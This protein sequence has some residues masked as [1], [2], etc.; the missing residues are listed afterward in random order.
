VD[1]FEKIPKIQNFRAERKVCAMQTG[2]GR[3]SDFRVV[4]AKRRRQN[5]IGTASQNFLLKT[6]SKSYFLGQG[7]PDFNLK[8]PPSGQGNRKFSL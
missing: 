3:W 7:R 6:C 4:T 5:L 2:G 8:K 1:F